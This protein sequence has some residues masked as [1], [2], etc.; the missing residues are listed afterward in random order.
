MAKPKAK[1]GA[2]GSPRKAKAA[3]STSPAN[4]K[5]HYEPRRRYPLDAWCA[6][7]QTKVKGRRGVKL[8]LDV[9]Y[10]GGCRH[11]PV[12]SIRPAA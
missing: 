7:P 9:S 5:P 2:K 8:R 12:A 11:L 4:E 10:F 6:S 3:K 1:K